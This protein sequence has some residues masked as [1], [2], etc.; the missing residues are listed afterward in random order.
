MTVQSDTG[1]A[2]AQNATSV[3][4]AL[5]SLAL[6]ILLAQFS[7]SV[8]IVA[9]PTLAQALGASFQ[10]VQWIVIAYL[11]AMT[12]LIVS[13]GRLGD[14]FGRRRLLLIGLAVF[15]VASVFC[16]VAPSLWFLIAARAV[17]GVGAAIMTALTMAVVGEA[18]AKNKVG[19]AM[20]LLGTTSAVGTALGPSLG[21]FLIAGFSW[22][23]IFLINVP[24]GALTLAIAFRTLPRD[25]QSSA[26]TRERFDVVGMLLLALMLTAYALAMTIGRGS[27]GALNVAL[28]L[29]AAIGVG[30]FVAVESKSASPLVRLSLF[31]N[32]ALS[33]GF[34]TSALVMTVI[35]A[36]FLVGPFYLSA[37]LGLDAG[38]VG[39]VMAVGPVVGALSGVP[40]GRAVD[41]FG[42]YRMSATGLAAMAAGCATLPFMATA[43][44]VAGYVPS[45]VLI[46]SGY[47]L[48]QAANN[49][50]VMTNVGSDQ[51][52]VVSGLLNL[53]RNL[54]VTTGAS[55]MGAVFA[56]A[57]AAAD[58]T[59]ASPEAVATGMRATFGISA[60]LVVVALAV[61]A[62]SR[63]A[64][65]R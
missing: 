48:F 35:M 44:G 43:F 42:T 7:G 61:L 23:A 63:F 34:A 38:R 58:I 10:Q 27:F 52:G 26:T 13:V 31:R 24:L 45:L 4:W 47:A 29:A 50:A 16:G 9:L 21:G 30:V 25:R 39:L 56:V 3:R 12:T 2:G 53:S 22:P 14:L 18:V 60:G 8:A 32:P 57:S 28:L 1:A 36:I 17:Q 59:K 46:T 64:G 62:V 33:A 6:S 41:R 11:L 54:G 40:A 49:T 51:R 20:G 37:S 65:R 5:A 15:T 19:S 55:A